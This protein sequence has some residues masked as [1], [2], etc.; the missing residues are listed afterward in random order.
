MDKKQ[1]SMTTASSGLTP[2]QR[3]GYYIID[4]RWMQ[5]LLNTRLVKK[6]LGSA[7]IRF[8]MVGAVNTLVGYG[9]MAIL[10]NVVHAGYWPST[11]CNYIFSSL[12]SF[13]LNSR[14]TFQVEGQDKRKLA[15]RFA[16]NIAVCYVLAYGL[17]RPL[18]E[19]LLRNSSFSAR[20]QGNLTMLAGMVLFVLFNYN[21]QRIFTFRQHKL[22]GKDLQRPTLKRPPKKELKD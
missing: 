17:A 11:A 14:F 8:G 6:M 10:Y 2:A 15:V 7:F 19:W 9:I 5:A 22:P 4:T 12:L 18:V 3:F 13:Y 1:K 21:G 20:A 16:I